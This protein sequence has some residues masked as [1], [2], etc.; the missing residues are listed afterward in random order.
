MRLVFLHL[1]SFGCKTLKEIHTL[2]DTLTANSE[3]V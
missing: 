3:P 1:E 2:D